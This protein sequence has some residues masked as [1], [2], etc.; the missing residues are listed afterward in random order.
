L[1][2]RCWWMWLEGIEYDVKK[3]DQIVHVKDVL[4]PELL[5]R[6]NKCFVCYSFQLK[7]DIS[8]TADDLY[9][10]MGR[11]FYT[12]KDT[13]DQCSGVGGVCKT[14][15]A[16]PFDQE[17]PGTC[18]K[19]RPGTKCCVADKKFDC[20]NRGGSCGLKIQG[21][22]YTQLFNGW[23]CRNE[24]ICLLRSENYFPYTKYIQEFNGKG[25]FNINI[26][27]FK[28]NDPRGGYAIV[29]N[30]ITD[31]KI[32]DKIFPSF[33]GGIDSI[34]VTSIDKVNKE[35]NVEWGVTEK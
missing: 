12:I 34:M 33:I 16:A 1:T 21:S 7:N 11:T 8:F 5:T 2:A 27:D 20:E 19:I 4:D 9:T 15:C 23:R 24:K 32:L 14:S 26:P 17:V 13:S 22:D 3:D 10:Y 25:R 29:F 28:A 31:A 35:C 18:N 6:Q 30:E